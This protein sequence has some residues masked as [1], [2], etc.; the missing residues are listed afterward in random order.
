MAQ[1]SFGDLRARCHHRAMKQDRIVIRPDLISLS[2]EVSVRMGVATGQP[3][4]AMAPMNAIASPVFASPS[5][6]ITLAS[7]LQGASAAR[8]ATAPLA[9]PGSDKAPSEG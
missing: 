5:Y 7:S 6:S 1:A 8:Q 9:S 4:P 3:A 2:G